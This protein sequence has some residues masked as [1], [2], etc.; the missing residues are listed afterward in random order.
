MDRNVNDERTNIAFIKGN[1]MD[2]PNETTQEELR[3]S[4]TDKLITEF[5]EQIEQL[6][7]KRVEKVKE[8]VNNH[9]RYRQLLKYRSSEIKRIPSTLSDEKME[10]ELFKIQQS[11]DLEVKKEATE[12][13]KFI[14]NEF[15]IF[16][17]N[18]NYFYF[19]IKNKWI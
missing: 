5:A 8:F 12:V 4:I 2:I 1:D 19:N 14:S 9:P 3:K 16:F 6:S 7:Q 11:L 13:L 15:S 10:L 17:D 18:K